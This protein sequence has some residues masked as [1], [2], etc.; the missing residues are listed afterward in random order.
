M[1]YKAENFIHLILDLHTKEKSS[2]SKTKP[3][4]IKVNKILSEFNF[5]QIKSHYHQF[6]PNGLSGF[7]LLSE[8]HFSI[9]TWPEK[10]TFCIDLFSCEDFDVNK[11]IAV[12]VKEFH[13]SVIKQQVIQRL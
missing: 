10:N 6:I 13:C 12:I 9:H 8:S 5:T 3:I 2:I 7:H 1:K 11:F 4:S